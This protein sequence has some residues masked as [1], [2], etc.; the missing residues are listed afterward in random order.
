MTN[1][2]KFNVRFKYDQTA[3]M[4][5][6][7]YLEIQHVK[8]MAILNR[9]EIKDSDIVIDVGAGTALFSSF[10]QKQNQIICCD[11]S[12][13]MLKSA[14][15]QNNSKFLVCCDSDFLPF[16]ENCCD[17]VACF[18]VIQNLP[19]PE[20]TLKQIWNI[21]K[22]NGTLILTAL[23][24]IFS[25]DDLE[26]LTNKTNFCNIELW[27]LPLEDVATITKKEKKS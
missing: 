22:P 24:K 4:Y 11:I 14:K 27:T 13:K 5:E 1:N 19:A 3:T 10:L 15:Q 7:R 8:Y 9:C 17:K 21:L 6:K 12:I 18:S 20:K 23:K 26:E 25:L 2:K 16:K